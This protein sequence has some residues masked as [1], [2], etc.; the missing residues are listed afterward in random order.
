MPRVIPS[1]RLSQLIAAATDVFIA[2]GYRRTQIDD[3]AQALGVAK[4]TIYGSVQSK[5]ALFD[6]ALRYADG[7][8]PLPDNST[9]PLP[10]PEPGTTLAW[11]RNR[12]T[13]EAQDLELTGA[14]NRTR[15]RDARQELT[16]VLRDL[17]ERMERNRRGIKMVDRCSLDQPEL[18]ALWFG[19]G[20]W[21]Q[22][23][24]LAQYLQRRIAK[25]HFRSVGD[26]AIAAR[27][28]LETVAF[29]AVHRHWD[30]SPQQ[31]AE[32]DV[33]TNVIELLVRSLEKE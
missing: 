31:V 30:P 13:G 1:D 12:L 9:L 14:L 16:A 27:L 20:R 26:A 21:A 3:V 10:T 23:A 29:W 4:G 15:V 24:A 2:Q 7:L 11:L 28:L 33:Q 18:A 5:E 8:E 32:S 6:A 19:E 22:H 17:Y 25:G